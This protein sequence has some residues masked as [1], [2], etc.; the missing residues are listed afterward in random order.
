MVLGLCGVPIGSANVGWGSF[1]LHLRGTSVVV[2]FLG[3]TLFLE[4]SQYLTCQSLRSR[5]LF[6]SLRGV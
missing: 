1:G 6:I 5:I 3:C 4:L 2:E